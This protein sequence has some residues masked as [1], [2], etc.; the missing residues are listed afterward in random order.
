MINPMSIMNKPWVR[1]TQILVKQQIQE[2]AAPWKQLEA[3][4]DTRK[5]KRY[6]RSI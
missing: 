6:A 4:A 3:V 1:A 5:T 2:K